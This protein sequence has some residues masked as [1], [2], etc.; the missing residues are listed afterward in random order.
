MCQAR[1]GYT[2]AIFI[3]IIGVG[4]QYVHMSTYGEHNGA[5]NTDGPSGSHAFLP[6]RPPPP[7]DIY[8]RT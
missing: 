3:Q 4:G 5:V 6:P 7:T 1:G 8:Q 2:L